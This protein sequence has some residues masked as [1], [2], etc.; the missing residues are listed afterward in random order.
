MAGVLQ[1]ADY[2]NVGNC[3]ACE[4]TLT[5]EERTIITKGGHFVEED[6]YS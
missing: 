1:W 4:E 5:T 2:E 6:Y 3:C